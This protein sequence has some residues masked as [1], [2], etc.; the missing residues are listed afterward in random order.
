MGPEKNDT[1]EKGGDGS[2]NRDPETH[3]RE[4]WSI[5]RLRPW[6]QL[7]AGRELPEALRGRVDTSDVVQQTLIKAWQGE[8]QFQGTTHEQRLAWLRMIVK[9]TIRDQHRKILGTQ[10]RGHGREQN[11]TDLLGSDAPGLARHAIANTH[12]ASGSLIAAED[13]LALAAALE[14]LPD[15]QRHVIE[16]RHLDGRSYADIAAELNK[17]EAAARMLWVRALRR[18]QTLHRPNQ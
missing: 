5:G 13:S 15:D 4:S 11:A 8:S 7:I 3:L 10:R 16:R 18:L 12:T 1:I 9:N 2:M 6:L 17:T 14:Q